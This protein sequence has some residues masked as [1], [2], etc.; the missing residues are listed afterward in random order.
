MA[1]IEQNDNNKIGK[2]GE[3]TNRTTERKLH[4]FALAQ[5]KRNGDRLFVKR[6]KKNKF[7]NETIT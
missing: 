2:I 1:D 3:A 4:S 7:N 6:S 5:G